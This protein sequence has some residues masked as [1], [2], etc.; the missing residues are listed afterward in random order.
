[1]FV[2][3]LKP[4]IPRGTFTAFETFNGVIKHAEN[5]ISG[6]SNGLKYLKC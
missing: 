3:Y 4:Q 1:M 6:E 5:M 2:V